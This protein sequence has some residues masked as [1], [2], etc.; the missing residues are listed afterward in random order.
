MITLRFSSVVFPGT[1]GVD[2][3]ERILVFHLDQLPAKPWPKKIAGVPCYLTTD[4]NDPGPI[5]PLR[6]RSRSRVQV[7]KD[8]DLR[9][10]ET[11]MDLIF[12]F[13]RDFFAKTNISITEI[14]FWGHIVIIVL[15]D[16]LSKD[17]ILQAVPRSVAQ[18]NCFYLF[19]SMMGRPREPSA[20]RI[21]QALLTQTDNSQ[22]ESLRSGVMAVR[23]SMPRRDMRYSLHQ[24][25]LFGID[26]AFSI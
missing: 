3:D 5:I 4:S 19:E 25:S 13:V 18:C 22:Y 8:L 23:A 1:Q 10:N 20:R 14:Q 24:V 2:F 26:L 11:S 6:F 7:A 17:E 16:E 12:D 15:E 21:K 9:N